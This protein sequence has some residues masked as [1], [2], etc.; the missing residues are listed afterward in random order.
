MTM[1][2]ILTR[3]AVEVFSGRLVTTLARLTLGASLTSVT[4]SVVATVSSGAAPTPVSSTCTV[5]SK[6]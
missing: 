6:T 1:S 4:V 5:T 3:V 2:A